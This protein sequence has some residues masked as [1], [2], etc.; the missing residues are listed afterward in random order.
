MHW[1]KQVTWHGVPVWTWHNVLVTALAT[2]IACFLVLGGMVLLAA[3]LDAPCLVDRAGAHLP[4]C[5]GI[6]F[7]V[8]LY[9]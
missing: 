4:L 8:G 2:T 3:V 6:G 9:I 1:R 7:V 5:W